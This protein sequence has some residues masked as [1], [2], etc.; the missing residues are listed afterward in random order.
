MVAVALVATT[1]PAS[2]EFSASDKLLEM[3]DWDSR[4]PTQ[5]SYPSVLNVY[6]GVVLY[7]YDSATTSGTPYCTV[8][9]T[10]TSCPTSLD[11]LNDT[12]WP[13]KNN[14]SWGVSA[15]F[16]YRG[17]CEE[18]HEWDSWNVNSAGMYRHFDG[19]AN[20][21]YGNCGIWG[22]GPEVTQY[23]SSRNANRITF[24]ESNDGGIGFWHGDVYNVC[25]WHSDPSVFS[26][27]STYTFNLTYEV[28]GH[29]SDCE[30]RYDGTAYIGTGTGITVTE[31][32]G[33][34]SVSESGSTD[35][36]T[37]ALTAQPSSDVVLS[38]VSADTGEATVS[39]AQ[40]TFTN[41]N[42]DTA[43]TV[44]V[45]GADDSVVDG[46]QTTAVTVAVVDGSSD[47]AYDS[48][49][50][51]TVS[52]TTSDDDTASF[53][54]SGTAVTVSEAGS[55]ATFTAVSDA[56][57]VATFCV[58]FDVGARDQNFPTKS[59]DGKH[60]LL[61]RERCRNPQCQTRIDSHVVHQQWFSRVQSHELANL[62][63]VFFV[64]VGL[65]HFARS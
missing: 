64:C 65:Q 37:V 1:P 8:N 35:T 16:T 43:Q 21:Q 52:V 6:D 49:A 56:T 14:S 7:I 3:E 10:G 48:V 40:L 39:P 19:T 51:S 45:T 61:H 58:F 9:G 20:W 60:L 28:V 34:T 2:A 30:G 62:I 63:L 32:G 53:T 54:L 50:D 29:T 15:V 4:N 44:T 42:W 33:S 57:G 11:T 17:T 38:V 41:S 24:G 36:F 27:G 22:V 12:N 31:S 55:T 23:D 46:S 5:A 18:P 25:S 59:A 13:V 47:D 26:V